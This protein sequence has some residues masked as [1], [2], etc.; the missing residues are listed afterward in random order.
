MTH[1]SQI[2]GRGTFAW[3]APEVGVADVLQAK[4]F[5]PALAAALCAVLIPS[6]RAKSRC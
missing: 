2:S 3:A 1:L 6:M 4:S 5:S